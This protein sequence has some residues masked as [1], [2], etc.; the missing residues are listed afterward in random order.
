MNI[1]RLLAKPKRNIQ[2]QSLLFLLGRFAVF[3]VVV[4]LIA[5]LIVIHL[6]TIPLLLL[7]I[8]VVFGVI[9]ILVI[10]LLLRGLLIGRGRWAALWLWLGRL[11]IILAP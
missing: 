3:V 8:V 11:G 1:E 6:V 10:T 4:L 2:I 9:I 5:V 7:A